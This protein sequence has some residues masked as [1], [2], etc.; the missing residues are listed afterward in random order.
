[1]KTL[2]LPTLIGLLCGILS[3]FGIGGGT[4]LILYL[5]NIAGIPQQA[6]QGI[7]LIY[8]LPTS[9][10]ALFSHF[11][12]GFIDKSSVIPAIITGS[13]FSIGAA[14]AATSLD[15]NVLKKIFGLFLIVIGIRELFS[16]NQR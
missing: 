9:A 2:V 10:T 15:V 5:A 8:F 13:I 12:N 7:N 14:I 16:K 11:K 6:A 4:I 3:G 1:M